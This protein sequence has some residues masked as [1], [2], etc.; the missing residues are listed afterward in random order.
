MKEM[1]ENNGPYHKEHGAA[2]G[3]HQMQVLQCI[4]GMQG[5]R[6]KSVELFA[7]ALEHGSGWMEMGWMPVNANGSK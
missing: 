2:R 3:M 4:Q 6:Y 7:T 5:S 1:T